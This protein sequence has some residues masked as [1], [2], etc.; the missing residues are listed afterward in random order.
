MHAK[1]LENQQ[2]GMGSFSAHKPVSGQS[3]AARHDAL[4]QRP[5]GSSQWHSSSPAH[6]ESSVQQYRRR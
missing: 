2:P 6:F 5:T 4:T 3:L 1:P